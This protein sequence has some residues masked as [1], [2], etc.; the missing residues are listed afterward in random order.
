MTNLDRAGWPKVWWGGE[1]AGVRF[2][3]YEPPA[4]ASVVEIM[5]LTDASAGM[6][7][8]VRRAAATWNGTDPVRELGGG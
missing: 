2:A 4:G 7:A 8:Y 1:D 3:Y 5:E 6:A